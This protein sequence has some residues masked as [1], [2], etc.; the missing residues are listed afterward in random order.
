MKEC[1]DEG[2][3]QGYCDG[4]LSGAHA[5]GITAH[6]TQCSSCS[7][8]LDELVSANDI[9]FAALT[10]EFQAAVPSGRLRQRIDDAIAGERV[11]NTAPAWIFERAGGWFASLGGLFTLRPQAFGYASLV[12]VLAFATIFGLA[13]W[14]STPTPPRS[15]V[16]VVA[17]VND[18]KPS[19]APP[20]VNPDYSE[21]NPKPKPAPI[22]YNTGRKPRSTSNSTS[23]GNKTV[24]KVK[25]LPGERS[26]LKTIA[27]LDSTIK[28]SNDRPMRPELRAEYERNLALVDRA[29]AAARSAAKSNPD[30]PD[31]AEFVFAAYQTKVD[32][33]NTVADARVY[34]RQP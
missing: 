27:A 30:D 32:L 18:V 23:S 34:N 17:P 33:L 15:E 26:Y 16:A 28:S 6:L 13:Y 24:A 11:M 31:A 12:A 5:E 3:L 25:L 1:L 19:P 14:K 2:T 29:L 7:T 22:G 4:E 9:V 20:A 21:I 10:P 8:Q